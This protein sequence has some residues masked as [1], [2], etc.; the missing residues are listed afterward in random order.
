MVDWKDPKKDLP[1]LEKG[2]WLLLDN[3]H[4][5]VITFGRLFK[6][7][8]EWWAGRKGLGFPLKTHDPVAWAYEEEI[9]LPNLSNAVEYKLERK[10]VD[11]WS[12]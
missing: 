3:G 8:D 4:E 10:K 5:D 1:E 7:P 12:L 6:E 2:C 9:N 11:D